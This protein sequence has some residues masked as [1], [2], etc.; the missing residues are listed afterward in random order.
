MDTKQVMDDGSLQ[1]W[2][3]ARLSQIEADYSPL[4]ASGTQGCATCR[5]FDGRGGCHVVQGLIQPTGISK[6]FMP[7][8]PESEEDDE[9]EVTEEVE[10]IEIEEEDYQPSLMDKAKK[11]L[12]FGEKPVFDT[13]SGF[14]MLND[15]TYIAWYTNPYQDRDKEWF[16]EKAIEDDIVYMQD[17]GDMPTLRFWHV[18]GLD[19]GDSQAVGKAGRFAFAIGKV[20]ADEVSQALKQYA[21]D[22]NYTLSH[23]FYY[24][25]AEKRDNVYH[26][27]HTFEIS[28]LDA[29]SASNPHTF[30][31]V[32][33]GEKMSI[34]SD[35]AKQAIEDALKPT[36]KTLE[37]LLKQGED[38]TKAA[39]AATQNGYK[40]AADTRINELE[41]SVKALN[42]K[43]DKLI[44]A[45]SAKAEAKPDEEEDPKKMDEK[46]DEKSTPVLTDERKAL[47]LADYEANAKKAL[48][49]RS[50]QNLGVSDQIIVGMGLG[51]LIGIDGGK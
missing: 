7:A 46:E 24:D 29:K 13:P 40:E 12:G 28:V 3:D 39:D 51:N 25:P 44:I 9:E 5:W 2:R 20:R 36:G 34:I 10:T 43:F 6:L 14:K 17:S 38:A 31:A 47:L 21:I 8:M 16:A 15:E 22:N 32:K 11:L 18:K 27:F 45:L 37:S 42:D 33:E 23:G 1:A 49:D 4:G 19:F 41:T 35:A 48:K 30:F 50:F 26:K